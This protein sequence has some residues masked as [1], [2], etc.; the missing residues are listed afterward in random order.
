[1]SQVGLYDAF[2]RFLIAQY[3]AGRRVVLI[4]DEAQNLSPS[5]LES[6]RM[7]SNINADKDQLL[8]IILVG[9]PQLKDLL[10]RP[11]MQQFAQRVSV[12]FFIPPLD[13]M[14]VE[15]Y[16][17]HRLKVAGR[18]I[19]LFTRRACER[20]A[21]AS[22]GIPRTINILSDT[23]LVYGYSAGAD[24]IDVGLVDEVLKDRVDYGGLIPG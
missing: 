13:P 20:I 6:L 9:Q 21:E 17:A 14:E 22:G 5:A 7:L 16:I 18:E 19:P 2:Q 4:V 12:H 3:G 1:M 15:R 10:S 11:D 8:Q 23:V 24:H